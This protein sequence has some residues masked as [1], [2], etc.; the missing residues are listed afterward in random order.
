MGFSFQQPNP[1]GEILVILADLMAIPGLHLHFYTKLNFCLLAN[2]NTLFSRTTYAY[3][4]LKTLQITHLNKI[5]AVSSQRD[6]VRTAEPSNICQCFFCTE[7]FIIISHLV[8]L[9]PHS[10]DTSIFDFLCLVMP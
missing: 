9:T 8:G 6:A 1:G 5:I 10:T 7:E 4:P 3:Q 2:S